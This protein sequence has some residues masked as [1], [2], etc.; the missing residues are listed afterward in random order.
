M[1]LPSHLKL[2]SYQTAPEFHRRAI[3]VLHL[4]Y[5]SS[6]ILLTRPFLLNLV[7]HNRDL[8]SRTKIAYEKLAKETL[9]AAGRSVELFKRMIQDQT[10]SSLTTFD[11]T[12]LLRCITICMCA[13]GYYKTFELKQL[14]DDCMKIAQSMERI[15][16]AKMI[17]QE[18]PQHIEALG[19]S[20]ERNLTISPQSNS[21]QSYMPREPSP[22]DIWHM[23]QV[24]ALQN[25]Q[26]FSLDIDDNG[27][28]D[29]NS[30]LI[31]Y[32]ENGHGYSN[33]FQPQQMYPEFN[34]R[35]Q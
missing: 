26:A 16:F 1:N 3:T 35:W 4:H 31:A 24:T 6:R 7:L 5:W 8:D 10:I 19:M 29:P 21:P 18:T 33:V 34:P 25:Q 20:L 14:A 32:E 17:S 27:I 23:Q 28:F 13:F 9:A 15:G 22:S 12:A 11:S 2:E 30:D